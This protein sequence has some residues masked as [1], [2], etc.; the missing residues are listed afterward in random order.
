MNQDVQERTV[1]ISGGE[2]C[3]MQSLALGYGHLT[4]ARN[5]GV[6]ASTVGR[7]V[8]KFNS[9]GTVNKKLYPK[10]RSYSKISTPVELTIIHTVLSKPGIYLKEIQTGVLGLN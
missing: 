7:I 5:V 8:N 2:L 10:H 6:D 4:V 1:R 9:T 3:G